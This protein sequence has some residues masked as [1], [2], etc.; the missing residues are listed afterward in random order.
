MRTNRFSHRSHSNSV[1]N[2]STGSKFVAYENSSQRRSRNFAKYGTKIFRFENFFNNRIFKALLN[3]GSTDPSLR[4]AAYN[5]LCALSVTFD[6]KIE[7]QLSETEGLLIP[8]NNTIFIKLIS[9]KLAVNEPHLTLEFLEECIQV[10][11][12]LTVSF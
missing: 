9:E 6:F 1:R 7:G 4:T 5:L 11:I 3:L 10:R 8:A 2:V 12:F